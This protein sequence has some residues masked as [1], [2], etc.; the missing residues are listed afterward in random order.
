MIRIAVLLLL[1]SNSVIAKD[2]GE[3]TFK[4]PVREVSVIVTEDGFYPNQMMAFEGEKLRF[5]ITSTAK[6]SQCFVLQKHEV[7][8]AADKGAVN[9]AEVIVENAGKFKFYCPSFKYEGTLTV[10][11]KFNSDEEV[12][13]P[14]SEEKPKYWLPRDYD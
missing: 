14:A 6:N 1:L 10:F 13:K 11:E 9:E 4:T 2:F 5:Y 7:F 12:R 3:K 8:V